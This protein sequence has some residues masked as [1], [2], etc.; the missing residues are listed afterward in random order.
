MREEAKR[1]TAHPDVSS[2]STL[3]MGWAQQGFESFLA[4]Q[5]ILMDF[6]TNKSAG[7]IKT[8]QQGL[9]D[10]EHSPVAILTEMTVEATA[11]LTEAQRVLLTL[12]QQENDIVMTGVKD[13]VG[14][15]PMVATLVERMRAGIDTWIEMQQDFL[16]TASKHAQKRMAETREGRG[17]DVTSLVEAA[18]E[19]MN[20]FV[21]AQKKF[22]D[23]VANENV[24]PAKAEDHHKKAD[25]AKLG[26]E[27]ATAFIEAQKK[28]LDLAGQQ[29]NVNLQAAN[30]SIELLET[31]R[32]RLV[33]DFSGDSLKNFVN[34][35]KDLIANMMKPVTEQ[36]AAPRKRPAQARR[37]AA[38]AAKAT[39]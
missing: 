33:P 11:N 26:R 22:L 36:K 6:V 7:A 39:A 17:L 21:R 30:K 3:L 28:L 2:F 23:V 13:R 24:K 38:K 15:S 16:T 12:A 27:A 32:P 9:T 5:R 18:R 10:P 8:L 4:T 31:L 19:A 34:A 20:D 14:A 35:E 25:I 29:V 1:P 37:R